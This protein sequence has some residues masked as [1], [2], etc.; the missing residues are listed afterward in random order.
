M[1]ISSDPS[2]NTNSATLGSFATRMFVTGQQFNGGDFA[3][4]LVSKFV[5]SAPNES[6]NY[7]S[8]S[9]GPYWRTDGAA[10]K[11]RTFTFPSFT[12]AENNWA[13]AMLISLDNIDAGTDQVICEWGGEFHQTFQ[14]RIATGAVDDL[15]LIVTD[16]AYAGWPNS[17]IKVKVRTGQPVGILLSRN[18]GGLL[19]IDTTNGV[20]TTA[21]TWANAT[22]QANFTID[23]L[24]IGNSRVGLNAGSLPCNHYM[25]AVFNSL[26][27][28]NTQR[29]DYTRDLN[30]FLDH[31][32][33]AVQPPYIGPFTRPSWVAAMYPLQQHEWNARLLKWHPRSA[34]FGGKLLELRRNGALIN[35]GYDLPDV[36]SFNGFIRSSIQEGD[37]I[38]I[39]PAIY[40]A[41]FQIGRN[42][43]GQ[44]WYPKNL[45]VL[46]ITKGGYRPIVRAPAGAGNLPTHVL[47]LDWCENITVENIDFDLNSFNNTGTATPLAVV[48]IHRAVNPTIKECR[49][50]NG[51]GAGA[52]GIEADGGNN[53]SGTLSIID[54][55][56]HKNGGPTGP[57]HQVYI[58][59][60]SNLPLTHKLII[61][62]CTFNTTRVGHVIKS[63]VLDNVIEGNYINST[64]NYFF[65]TANGYVENEGESHLIQLCA[66]G[67]AIVRNN[68]LTKRDSRGN[69]WL[70][71][72]GNDR[73]GGAP[74][75][76]EYPGTN[77]VATFHN[78]TF[79][80]FSQGITETTPHQ[81]M[82]V[83]GGSHTEQYPN[84]DGTIPT[85]PNQKLFLRDNVY[86]GF[87]V[88]TGYPVIHNWWRTYDTTSVFLD[89]DLSAINLPGIDAGRPF[90]LKKPI[91]SNN[92][93]AGTAGFEYQHHLSSIRRSD[94]SKGASE[95]L[96][97]RWA[98]TGPLS[99]TTSTTRTVRLE[100]AYGRPQFGL[101][102]RSTNHSPIASS[103]TH[104]GD[105][106]NIN[107]TT[108]SHGASNIVA[109]GSPLDATLDDAVLTVTSVAALPQPATISALVPMYM[110]PGTTW[111]AIVNSASLV[112]TVA[113]VNPANGPGTALHEGYRTAINTARANQ[114]R[115]I[116]YVSTSG[117]TRTQAEVR[118]DMDRY[119]S[120]YSV[121]GFFLDQMST[122]NNT[123]VI[124][125]YKA[126]YDYA[127]TLNPNFVVIGN[128]AGS[129]RE[130]YVTNNTADVFVTFV[131]TASEFSTYLRPLW[132]NNYSGRR[133]AALVHSVA[134]QADMEAT[135]AAVAG[136][137]IGYCYVTNDVPPAAFDTVAAYWSAEV[138]KLTAT[139]FTVPTP[140]PKPTFA[141]NA[142]ATLVP[143][144]M[145][146]TSTAWTTLTNTSRSVNTTLILNPAN[147]PGTSI[148]ADY[149]AAVG[150][151]RY[152]GAR[153]VCFVQTSQGT[154]AAAAVKKDIDDYI[155][156]YG[157]LDGYFLDSLPVESDT[158]KIAYYKDL[159]SYVK[160]KSPQYQ[161]IGRAGAT[162]AEA[163]VTQDC[164]DVFVTFEGTM[165]NFL[166]YQPPAWT[167]NYHRSRFCYWVHSASE[168]EMVSACQQASLQNVGYL[169]ATDQSATLASPW[170]VLAS[171]WI[172][173]AAQI[174]ATRSIKATSVNETRA[175]PAQPTAI[176][177]N[178]QSKFLVNVG[179][180]QT[181]TVDVTFTDDSRTRKLTITVT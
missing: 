159:Y 9:L 135:V 73:S 6:G 44:V 95:I 14:F 43:A 30:A 104:T 51:A 34:T 166:T 127:K 152:Q 70:M 58:H 161:V 60:P 175:T 114:T 55:Y 86:A 35:T 155:L 113:I 59:T 48:H 90:T 108:W 75:A 38:W 15:Y 147:G 124:N 87:S 39:Y 130:V 67:N 57:R 126:L 140:P 170:S 143:S 146:I 10:H 74:H 13:I 134:T 176:V 69:A 3:A 84:S 165:T 115:V 118:A 96:R 72:F 107:L 128:P 18:A 47:S 158:A 160:L 121:D 171:Y 99:L 45:R 28:N 116:G 81:L 83:H 66:G 33:P 22:P 101:H 169:Y 102:V 77:F 40:D 145:P 125:H 85:M 139:T 93:V 17:G 173:Q 103:P 49:I 94:V 151:A 131:G 62:G 71:A 129:T 52:S 23:R 142:L 8:D 80:C 133:F 123:T 53:W 89:T 91:A 1:R 32:F 2:R 181:G 106:G 172:N 36:F 98:P 12:L 100:D 7:S 21:E 110:A 149:S 25:H 29:F 132:M 162:L 11:R 78:N 19:R 120:F 92:N 148:N 97:L 163:Y 24:T 50:L 27:I 180:E 154:R 105:D 136:N 174:D 42:E 119:L 150:L 68:I 65:N 177:N 41:P 37:E 56:F 31:L 64:S 82:V 153:V 112:N 76:S 138:T 137:N 167:R 20:H 63:R 178:S 144:Y 164:A 46:G 122:E 111:D 16:T 61:R 168:A 179:L 26:S 5:R 156:L 157:Q 54:C 141:P 117:G 79:V 88:T 4:E 109:D